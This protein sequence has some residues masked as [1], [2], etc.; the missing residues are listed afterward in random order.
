MGSFTVIDRLGIH[1]PQRL[2]TR[3]VESLVSLFD[4]S[5]SVQ[6]VAASARRSI[7]RG[8]IETHRRFHTEEVHDAP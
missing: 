2:T 5:Q 8:S 7:I 3:M 6:G 4:I 1:R